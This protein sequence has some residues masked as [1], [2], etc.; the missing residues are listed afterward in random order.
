MTPKTTD[1]LPTHISPAKGPGSDLQ[2]SNR[3]V[4]QKA[5]QE[6]DGPQFLI[7]KR[8]LRA[9]TTDFASRIGG[10]QGFQT[11][12]KRK[13]DQLHK[14]ECDAEDCTYKSAT[15]LEEC[16]QLRLGINESEQLVKAMQLGNF[17]SCQ[18]T[19]FKLEKECDDL[20]TKID[21]HL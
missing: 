15:L 1:R 20:A 18:V 3:R 14:Y 17:M 12:L 11:I 4:I 21:V 2:V 6:M 9:L 8:A 19:Y 7:A 10:I 13:A 16:A 5:E